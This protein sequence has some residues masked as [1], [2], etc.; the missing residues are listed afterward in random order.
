MSGDG[1]PQAALIVTHTPSRV[2]PG[3]KLDIPFHGLV[4]GGPGTDFEVDGARATGSRVEIR[5]VGPAAGAGPEWQA[6]GVGRVAVNWNMTTRRMLNSGDELRVVDTF[7]RFL[8]GRDLQ[9]RY[10]ETIY[11]MTILDMPTGLA[12]VRYLNEMLEREMQ[13]RA[14]SPARARLAVVSLQ[15]GPPTESTLHTSHDVV[16]AL[17]E[18]VRNGMPHNWLAARA[19]ELEVVVV[20]PETSREA[21]DHRAQEWLQAREPGA[22]AMKIGVAEFGGVVQDALTLLAAARAEAGRRGSG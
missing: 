21:L 9:D 17:A 18:S 19:G 7:F 16:R 4:L 20:A 11:H 3:K 14:R 10:Y 2:V 12:N 6:D 1:V 13:R 8:C 22:P 15:L 5:W